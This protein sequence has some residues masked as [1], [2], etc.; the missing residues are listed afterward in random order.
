MKKSSKFSVHCPLC[1]EV[2]P[3]GGL[4]WHKREKHGEYSEG[5]PQ[6]P[7]VSKPTGVEKGANITLS[8]GVAKGSVMIG[9]AGETSSRNWKHTK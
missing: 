7:S 4:R 1:G 2:F 9:L 5:L 6:A 3:D 8:K